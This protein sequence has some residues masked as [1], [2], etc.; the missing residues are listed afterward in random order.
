[1]PY[2]IYRLYGKQ[3]GVPSFVWAMLCLL[4]C[5]VL[6]QSWFVAVALFLCYLHRLHS[7]HHLYPMHQLYP[8]PQYPMHQLYHTYSMQHLYPTRHLYDMYD[9]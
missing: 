8:V 6:L 2:C 1:M 9:M 3:N 4:L 7:M 5:S